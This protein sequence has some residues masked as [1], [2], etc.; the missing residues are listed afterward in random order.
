LSYVVGEQW[1]NSIDSSLFDE[2]LHLMD[3]HRQTIV[4][5]T[6]QRVHVGQVYTHTHTH[7]DTHAYRHTHR[8]THTH[9]DTHAY[10]HTH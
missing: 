1:L 6:Q 9:T 2:F 4:Y 5:R 10:R 8:Q 7:T 3:E